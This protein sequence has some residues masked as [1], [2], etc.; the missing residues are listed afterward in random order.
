MDNFKSLHKFYFD[1][2]L[3]ARSSNGTLRYGQAIFNH[4]CEVRP[5]L[6]EKARGTDK[7]PF[8]VE[9]LNDSRWD[10]F[11]AFIETEWYK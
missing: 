10:N 6:A 7:D 3:A 11:V 5:D 4:L 2:M 1:A 8:Y 9:R